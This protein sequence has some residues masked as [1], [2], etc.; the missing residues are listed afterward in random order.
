MTHGQLAY[1]FTH[2]L[3]CLAF[4]AARNRKIAPAPGADI[5]MAKAG[6][7]GGAAFH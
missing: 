4:S 1:R 6:A 2:E 7:A 3:L 5:G